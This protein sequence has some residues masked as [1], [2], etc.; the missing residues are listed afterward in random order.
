M[1]LFT[2]IS[3]EHVCHPSFW[4]QVFVYWSKVCSHYHLKQQS[5][6]LSPLWKRLD[7]H[8]SNTFITVHHC[9]MVVYWYKAW[10]GIFNYSA[11]CICI[12]CNSAVLVSHC[13]NLGSTWNWQDG[14]HI[15]CHSSTLAVSS[16]LFLQQLTSWII[17]T[18]VYKYVLS[19]WQE[20][21]VKCWLS[22][23]RN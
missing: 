23:L 10:N 20:D 3:W 19:M 6:G 15:L 18:Y 16:L 2:I 21:G 9:T 7:W 12:V 14:L 13:S 4:R 5:F 17:H 1:P 22:N 8:C 11:M